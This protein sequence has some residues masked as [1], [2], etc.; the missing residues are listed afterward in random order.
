MR[1]TAILF[2]LCGLAVN[3]PAAT[4]EVRQ[5]GLGDFLAIW[6]AIDAASPGDEVF[7]WPGTYTEPVLT[8]N[9]D[10]VLSSIDGHEATILDGGGSNRCLHVTAGASV[11]ITG[12][13]IQNCLAY[14]GAGIHV[15]QGSI[16]TVSN[17]H[18]NN[19]MATY[20][21]GAGFV[22]ETGSNLIFKTCWF[23]DNYAPRNA[24][25]VGVS[26][27]STC[28]FN[29]C[30]FIRNRTNLMAGA[31]ANFAGSLMV[32]E[33]C[34]FFDN[35]GGECGA[36]RIYG[37]PAVIKNNSFWGNTSGLGSIYLHTDDPVTLSYNTIAGEHDGVGVYSTDSQESSCNIYYGNQ[38]GPTEGYLPSDTDMFDDPLFCNITEHF[39]NEDFFWLCEDSMAL[40]VNNDC[41][42]IGGQESV[43][44]PCGPVIVE[45]RSWGTLKALFR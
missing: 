38:N 13:T 27:Q 26:L 28:V 33:R 14:D 37:S 2:L 36:I 1:T 7:V 43:C 10:I 5:D 6:E 35:S 30:I 42:L 12:F 18:F 22:R 16:A 11:Q 39:F 31:I 4:W 45:D 17:C 34:V 44:E 23:V 20:T 40:P 19:N 8:L 29:D 24:G 3:S 41:G 21:G 32:I 9:Q 15:D 25:A